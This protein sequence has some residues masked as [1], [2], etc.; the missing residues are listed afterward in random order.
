M[1]CLRRAVDRWLFA[2][3]RDGF[4]VATGAGRADMSSSIPLGR[5][6]PEAGRCRS[7]TRAP[8]PEE[9]CAAARNCFGTSATT[10]SVRTPDPGSAQSGSL[11]HA[12]PRRA[13]RLRFGFSEA[14]T[15]LGIAA[16]LRSRLGCKRSGRFQLCRLGRGRWPTGPEQPCRAVRGRARRARSMAAARPGRARPQPGAGPAIRG[17]GQPIG[18]HGAGAR[19]GAPGPGP[20][21]VPVWGT[22]GPPFRTRACSALGRS[23]R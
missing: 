16:E 20:G 3:W 21:W 15:T 1:G 4:G 17:C 18:Q 9:L 14:P 10:S 23:S 5:L 22:R 19:S 13:P 8:V 11:A 2:R 6:R 7:S 12:A